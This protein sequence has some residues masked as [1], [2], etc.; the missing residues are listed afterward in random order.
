M[1]RDTFCAY[2][3]KKIE[4]S[5][6]IATLLDSE[7]MNF[8][9]SACCQKLRDVRLRK[10]WAGKERLLSRRDPVLYQRLF[11]SL[12]PSQANKLN[13]QAGLLP[14]SNLSNLNDEFQDCEL[15]IDQPFSNN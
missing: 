9:N 3:K 14:S 15:L 1:G 10:A 12:P 6:Y 13:E 7:P 11:G 8:C 5:S 2:C 4:G